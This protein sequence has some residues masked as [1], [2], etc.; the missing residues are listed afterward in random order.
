MTKDCLLKKVEKQELE[1]KEFGFYWE[2]FHQLFE[3][4]QSEC[5]EIQEAWDNKNFEH[6]QEEVGDLIHAA[7][8]L[9]IFFKLDPHETMS[10][11]INKFQKRFDA[12]VVLAQND[13]H[14]HLHQQSFDILLNYWKRAKAQVK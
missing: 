6:L 2:D 12:L 10:K 7:V 4:I 13:G 14:N 8:S 5:S 9:A 1:A 3:Q 11:S